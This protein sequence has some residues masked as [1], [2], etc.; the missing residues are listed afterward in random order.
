MSVYKRKYSVLY[1]AITGVL[2]CLFCANSIV[3]ANPDTLAPAVGN[4][5]VYQ[6]MRDMMDERLAAHQ[7]P[8][9]EFIK[10][11]ANTAKGLSSIPY[12]EEEFM[13][14]IGACNATNMLTR[15]KTTLTSAGGKIQVIFVKSE[16]EL[17]VFDG[18]RAW[19]HAGTYVTVFALES[20]KNSKEGRRKI[21]GRL[22]HEI[23]ARS[24]RAKELF[25]QELN[26][27]NPTTPEEIAAFIRTARQNFEKD[28]ISLQQQIEQNGHVASQFLAREF[29]N[30]TF[31]IHPDVINRDYMMAHKPRIID[32]QTKKLQQ[33]LKSFDIGLTEAY[34]NREEMHLWSQ[35]LSYAE[36]DKLLA[37]GTS[38]WSVW[39]GRDYG[40]PEPDTYF[41][42]HHWAL[43]NIM[44]EGAVSKGDM[45]ILDGNNDDAL[46]AGRYG[47]YFVVL[48]RFTDEEEKQYMPWRESEHHAIYLVPREE[49]VVFLRHGLVEAV[50][51][52]L[53]TQKKAD[54][55]LSKIMTYKQF[56]E[57]HRLMKDIIRKKISLAEIELLVSAVDDLRNDSSLVGGISLSQIAAYLKIPAKDK[58]FLEE[59]LHIL[60]TAGY[61]SSYVT[62]TQLDKKGSAE[63]ARIMDR[64]N[65]GEIEYEA[66]I[67]KEKELYRKYGGERFLLSL[68]ELEKRVFS[69]ERANAIVEDPARLREFAVSLSWFFGDRLNPT[70]IAMLTYL[71][72]YEDEFLDMKAARKAANALNEKLHSV[73][74]DSKLFHEVTNAWFDHKVEALDLTTAENAILEIS[75]RMADIS[76]A[77]QKLREQHIACLGSCTTEKERKF[78]NKYYTELELSFTHFEFVSR[79]YLAL[80]DAIKKRKGGKGTDAPAGS[81]YS[82][83]KYLCDHSIITVDNAISGEVLAKSTGEEHEV[84]QEALSFESIK[85]DLRGLLLHLHL[86]EKAP[87]TETG[88]DARYY[89]PES[90]K[91]KSAEILP[92]LEQFR[93]K[94]LRPS[95]A[96][97]DQVYEEKIRPIISFSA[98]TREEIVTR[99]S[100]LQSICE[101]NTD[102]I[103]ES[104]KEYLLKVAKYFNLYPEYL[105]KEKSKKELKDYA[106][107]LF[108]LTSAELASLSSPDVPAFTLSAIDEIGNGFFAHELGHL[109]DDM[110]SI[111]NIFHLAE[112]A[113]EWQ[114]SQHPEIEK[115]L[116]RIRELFGGKYRDENIAWRGI[117]DNWKGISNLNPKVI[118]ALIDD[119]S[120]YIKEVVALRAEVIK[121]IKEHRGEIGEKIVNEYLEEAKKSEGECQMNLIQLEAIRRD[122]LQST[123]GAL[124]DV[125]ESI[126]KAL[127]PYKEDDRFE[128][129]AQL[130]TGMQSV[131]GNTIKVSYIWTNLL[132]NSI[133]AVLAARNKDKTRKG[134]ITVK[135][136]SVSEGAIK[137][138][139]VAVSDDGV[140]IP[141]EL[142]K[143]GRLF[144]KGVTTK[145]Y[146]NGLGLYLIRQTVEDMGGTIE[147]QSELGKG[148]TF[149]IR[150]PIT[151]PSTMRSSATDSV[152]QRLISVSTTE[153]PPKAEIGEKPYKLL[154]MAQA[155]LN[156]P[157]FFVIVT[158]GTGEITVTDELRSLFG[159]M[160]KPV[161]VRSAHKDEGTVH[162]FS[163]V[164]DSY[165]GITTIEPT[166]TEIISDEQEE[167]WDQGPRPESLQSAYKLIVEGATE[168]YRVKK[169]LEAHHITDFNPKQMNAVVMEQ[170]DMDVF[171]MFI[172]SNQNNPDE[173]LIHYEVTDKTAGT[174]QEPED[175]FGVSRKETGGVI[176]Y[177]KKT[178]EL[179]QNNLD[180]KTQ[181][182]LKQFGEIAGQIEKMF[183]VQQIELGAA[184]G[185]VYVF[186][187]K[188]IDLSKPEDA[189]RLAHY[190]TMSDE[191]N[192][193]GYGYYHLPVL[194]ID[195]LE[196]VHPYRYGDEYRA[197]EA[198]YMASDKKWDGKEWAAIRKF[199]E[200]KRSEYREELL[201]FQAEHPEYMLVIKDAEDVMMRDE[202]GNRYEFLNR[203]ASK[204]KVV[205][206]GRNQRAIRHEDWENVELGS[207]T[208]IPPEVSEGRH[209]MDAFIYARES[210]ERR[211]DM[212]FM[213]ASKKISN[214][215]IQDTGRI[216]TGDYLNVLSN[217]DGVF[218]WAGNPLSTS[219]RSSA[220]G[221]AVALNTLPQEWHANELKVADFIAELQR[222]LQIE[223]VLDQDKST[224]IF[225]EKV[226]FDN[227]L[228][229]L[230]PKL[231]KSGM[232]IAV[233]ATNDRQRA[234]IEELN[235]GKPDNEKIIYADTV[236][237][238]R[239]KVH[240][241]RYYYFKVKGDPDADLQGITTF[242][243]TEIVK[244]IIDALGKISGIV[245]RERIELLHEAA[246][247]FA[248]A[249]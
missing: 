186:Q 88:K 21:I 44:I 1:R 3:L 25:D 157:P 16:D 74:R 155:G 249:A 136:Q 85:D 198:A 203:L 17:P 153:V 206:R 227:G 40:I 175:R 99:L 179:G 135:T 193:I 187:S 47:P 83:F 2:V 37:H 34:R 9:D 176:T 246:R 225:S 19:G 163:G 51:L 201:R 121:W 95:V 162:S 65:R 138:I 22:F 229:V 11:R 113:N 87:G 190:E 212:R 159:G 33:A 68:P 239:T 142:L 232:R 192:A 15:L 42:Q 154:K 132:R 178:H 123:E 226:T 43:L 62:S 150:L 168:G 148:T 71:F 244:K 191:L 172:T 80:A 143:S 38:N 107:R 101:K 70:L 92:I 234:L 93:G 45:G 108:I 169:Y 165:K 81:I 100:R 207:I 177:N 102:E 61:L 219:S 53:I 59:K 161:I 211:S 156:V 55:N 32:S 189:P 231:V 79:T 103:I 110:I 94:D 58:P 129:Q 137:F 46:K 221:A 214:A 166:K 125:N 26:T 98:T 67:E 230:L 4:P 31:A 215:S 77:I 117:L 69:R 115:E 180:E 76:K 217:I 209:F 7:D 64:V 120:R 204:A 126:Q 122:I 91:K 97:L 28:N 220:T 134:I 152:E 57:Y 238:I 197:L 116:K 23:R 194:V 75:E 195:S 111:S 213:R 216:A 12:L 131:Y 39:N 27:K 50:K 144:Q 170:I 60:V 208:V 184:N 41:L 52:G 84:R 185:K 5:K 124:I 86:I 236:A 6:A 160:K 188:D 210:D 30:L 18:Q 147:V 35:V 133:D 174:Q 247:K 243:I 240:S 24:T 145:R 149:T 181:N 167:Y 36:V 218:V 128:V 183:G 89:V 248:E 130:A 158:D 10:A 205:V 199:E 171:G 235:Q 72:S 140:G 29:E 146:G 82:I 127:L 200:T 54:E 114:P 119:L 202:R 13:R 139:E 14:C 63:M 237:D 164:F 48:D 151:Q 182:V 242:D 106:L 8:I 141:E 228:G 241:A 173:V 90:V 223:N 222:L 49:A 104:D 233:V 224:F 56:V 245:E 96:L 105:T 20:E 78:F 196:K 66:Q 73:R 118:L 109:F 112:Y